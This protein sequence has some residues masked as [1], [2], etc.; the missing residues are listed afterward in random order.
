MGECVW[1]GIAGM[2]PAQ[3]E[4]KAASRSGTGVVKCSGFGTTRVGPARLAGWLEGE[5]IRIITCNPT[6]GHLLLLCGGF[7]YSLC[8]IYISL[9]L[10]GKKKLNFQATQFAPP[11]HF[12]CHAPSSVSI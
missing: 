9:S 1:Q 3:E 10:S 7:Q 11:S 5:V 8:V 2:M 6:P 12:S 4:N